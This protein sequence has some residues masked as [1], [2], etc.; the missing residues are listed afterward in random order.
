VV[1]P[2]ATVEVR[3]APGAYVFQVSP[4]SLPANC[5]ATG[6]VA[7][8]VVSG[9]RAQVILPVTCQPL[10]EIRVSLNAPDPLQVF[11]VQQPD[12]CDNYYVLCSTELLRTG[13]PATFRVPA[14]VYRVRLLDVPTNCQVTS[15]N[16]AE[17]VVNHGARSE[18]VFDVACQ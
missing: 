12:G 1:Q 16:P 10:G 3:V 7:V 8:E 4:W 11:R 13:S 15:P 14:G 6:D 2:S 5:Q 18:L 9:A 17:V